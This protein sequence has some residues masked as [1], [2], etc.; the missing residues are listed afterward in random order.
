MCYIVLFA[1]K[2]RVLC[3]E[4]LAIARA[5]ALSCDSG[6]LFVDLVEE[7]GAGGGG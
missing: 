1:P 4:M 6:V 2:F 3:H 5:Q 7:G